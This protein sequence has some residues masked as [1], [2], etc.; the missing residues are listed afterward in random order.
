MSHYEYGMNEF[1]PTPRPYSEEYSRF[2]A[3]DV[4]EDAFHQ[5]AM[6]PH[7]LQRIALASTLDHAA[8]AWIR[9]TAFQVTRRGFSCNINAAHGGIRGADLVVRGEVF[10]FRSTYSAFGIN[11]TTRENWAWLS[12]A[13][14]KVE[15]AEGYGGVVITMATH[16]TGTDARYDVLQGSTEFTQPAA[17]SNA[18]ARFDELAEGFIGH[19]AVHIDLGTVSIPARRGDVHLDV[20]FAVPQKD[21]S[22]RPPE[23]LFEH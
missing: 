8:A 10:Q 19:P 20:L 6:D 14:R 5:L 18:L 3:A 11:R 17:R 1:I 16:L 12:S 2:S 21:S 15:A 9:E 23:W 7:G 4:V 13:F 22:S